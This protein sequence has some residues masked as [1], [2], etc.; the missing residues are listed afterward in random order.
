DHNNHDNNNDNE[1]DPH[2]VAAV[3]TQVSSTFTP[4]GTPT[5][6]SPSSWRFD[7]HTGMPLLAVGQEGKKGVF[8]IT[9]V[10]GG[11]QEPQV[12]ATVDTGADSISILHKSIYNRVPEITRNLQTTTIR[13]TEI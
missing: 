6:S 5:P 2:V 7:P 4:S 12:Q 13:I 3:G 1:I 8:S 9:T 11:K 10:V